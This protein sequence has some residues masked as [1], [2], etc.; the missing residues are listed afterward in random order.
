MNVHWMLGFSCGLLRTPLNPRGSARNCVTSALSSQLSISLSITLSVSL[1]VTS[2]RRCFTP[3]LKPFPS[4]FHSWTFHGLWAPHRGD[5]VVG[6]EPHDPANT[7][8]L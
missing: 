7:N 3:V 4:L 1:P 6:P 8:C 5:G 2:A